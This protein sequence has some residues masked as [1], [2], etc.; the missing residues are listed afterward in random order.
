MNTRHQPNSGKILT[1]AGKIFYSS[2]HADR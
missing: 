1:V 2:S